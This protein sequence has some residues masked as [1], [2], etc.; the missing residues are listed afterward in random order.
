MHVLFVCRHN[1]GRSQI[2]Q[3]L[4]E[5]IAG[6]RHQARSAGTTP[7]ERAWGLEDPQGRPIDEVRAIRDDIRQ[8]VH[9]LAADLDQPLPATP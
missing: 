6:D 1:A 8:R 9:E 3:A 5:R 7:A 4:F 2:S